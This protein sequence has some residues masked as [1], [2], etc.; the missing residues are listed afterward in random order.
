MS[1]DY[2][3]HSSYRDGM[4]DPSLAALRALRAVAEL[5]SFTAAGQA[6]GYT[7]SAV[8]RQVAALE[9]AAGG[10]LFERHRYGVRLTAAGSRLLPRAARALDDLDAAFRDAPEPV[11]TSTVRVGAIP[12]AAAGLVTDAL[13]DLSRHR[14]DVVVTMREATTPA[15]VR[16]L[17][18]GTF[19]LA[20]LAQTPP[21]R[22]LDTEAPALAVDLICERELLV[23]VASTHPFAQRGTVEVA[24]LADQVWVASRSDDGDSLLGV[25]PG[26]PGRREIRYVARD[27]NTKLALVA[28][29][30]A[31]TTV[32][33]GARLPAG[34]HLVGLRGEPHER[35]RVCVARPP[36]RMSADVQLVHEVLLSTGAD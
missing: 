25:W 35:R 13:A 34:V 20:V 11:R 24:E 3:A 1:N 14:P 31:V 27:W 33:R 15:L 10:A 22:P 26:L 2:L 30:L 23:A 21:F 9:T 4:A 18:Q 16:A 36:G 19:D 17:R 6:L 12:L 8:S 5:G 7:Q 28:A 29:G 32:S